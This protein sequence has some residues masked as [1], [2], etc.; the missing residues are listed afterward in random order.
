M[1]SHTPVRTSSSQALEQG[2]ESFRTRAWGAAFSQLS[3]ADR[4]GKLEPADLLL[5]AQSALLT[6]RE[7]EGADLLA[8]A[9]QAFLSAGEVQHAVRCAFWLGF[10]LLI[11]GE[12]AKAG[13]WLSRAGRLLES[14]SDCVDKGYLLLPEG[15]RLFHAGD[16]QAAHAMF[17]QSVAI[18]ERFRDRELVTL[19]LQGQGRALIRQGEIS[20]GVALLD[21]AMVAVTAGEVSPLTAGGIYCSVLEACG[22]ICD[23]QRAQEWT[24]ALDHW[25]SSQ[26]DLVPY[27]GH[28]LVRR[29]ELLQL[30]GA[31]PDALEGAQRASE[32]LSHPAPK[33]AVGSAFYQIGEVYRLRGKF[34]EAEEAFRQASQWLRRIGPGP[35]LLRLAQGQVGEANAA[36]RRIA[37]EAHLPGPRARILD[38]YVEIA[39]ASNDLAA[40][41]RASDELAGIAAGHDSPFLQALS[42]RANG[43]VLLA[44]GDVQGALAALRQSWSLWSDLQA[45]YEAARVRYLLGLTFRKLGD[46][47]NG[48]QE[49]TAARQTFQ[50]LQAVVE[51]AQVE[52]LLPKEARQRSGPL[53]DR[54]LQVLRLVAA[55]MT[56]REIASKLHISEKTVA[57]H[58]SN[59]FMKLDLS[60]RT[61]AAAY[62]YD[63]SLV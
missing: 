9:H 56:N 21:E 6:G 25:C 7:V 50:R 30:H 60:S 58:I 14:Q 34:A 41:R 45:P 2:R 62:A 37:E 39:L 48:N 13:G 12:P 53:T 59:I 51:L 10:T 17:A 8:R 42:C 31:W 18:G 27:R 63:H 55:G 29:A 44:E 5:L 16:P 38:A 61:A 3:I 57:R 1:H 32:W 24:S 54:E 4:E 19:G 43:A 47:Q 15:Y 22:E 35:A 49:L 26:P 20:R 11:G 52:A 36:I 40:A 23:L 28:C 46:V 33:P